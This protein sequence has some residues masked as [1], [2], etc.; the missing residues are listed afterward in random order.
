MMD[1]GVGCESIDGMNEEGGERNEWLECGGI[2][3]SKVCEY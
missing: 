2:G 3:N 1:M